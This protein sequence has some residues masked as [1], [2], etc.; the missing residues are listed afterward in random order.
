MVPLRRVPRLLAAA[1]VV[2]PTLGCHTPI[3]VEL[4]P[5]GA[6]RRVEKL[7]VLPFEAVGAQLAKG[8]SGAA[9]LVTGRV[10]EELA[11]QARFELIP[12][13]ESAR[14][15][16]LRGGVDPTRAEVCRALHAGFGVDAVLFGTLHRF[17]E[18]EGSAEGAQR[19]AA[20]RFEL[21]LSGPGGEPLWRGSYDEV[22]RGLV[23]EPRSLSRARE[24]GFRFVTAAA[25]ARY[26]A[27]ELVRALGK[28][29]WR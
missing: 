23:D 19:P 10:L 8:P 17:R 25:L 24:R 27:R 7:A 18:R 29:P 26:G 12:P 14:L 5:E 3:Q 13:V 9:E 1:L 15:L 6:G 21:E 16:E 22:Q 28:A 20:V 11:L 4:T 2:G